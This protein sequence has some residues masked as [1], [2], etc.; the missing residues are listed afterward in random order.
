MKNLKRMLCGVLGMVLCLPAA[1]S[2]SAETADIS[3]A[4]EDSGVFIDISGDA[5]YGVF[6]YRENETGIT[7][8]SC[9]TSATAADIPSEID[10]KPVTEIGD[11]AFMNCEFLTNLVIPA[12]VQK[13][14]ESAFSN[15]PM[16][17]TVTLPEGL[18]ELGEGAFES[19]SMLSQVALPS[20][21]TELP[22]AAFYNCSYLPSFDVPATIQ[23]IGNEAFYSC[24]ALKEVTLPEGIETIGDYAFQNCQV[25]EQV[26]LPASC[27]ELGSYVF[28]GCQGLTALDVADGNA[29]YASQD[30]V[31]FTADGKTLI[32]Y[33]QAKDTASYQV[34][35]DCTALA[36]WSF[37]GSTVLEQIDLGNVT[38]IGEDCFYYCTSLKS[39][40]IPEGVTELKGAA[41]AY[42]LSMEE[43]QLPSTMKKLGNHCFYSCAK[44]KKLELPD[45]LTTLGDQCLYNCVALLQLNV[46]GSITEIGE[47]AIGY[48]TPSD[49]SGDEAKE[50]GRLH[51][52]N[53]GSKAVS[54]YMQQWKLHAYAPCLI[55]GAVI[56][57]VTGS[58]LL[59]VVLHRRRNQIRPTSRHA[60]AAKPKKRR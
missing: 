41:F 25:L 19:C 46:P 2:V 59:L 26:T 40:T 37:I 27:T 30:G 9:Q 42:C 58:I 5:T 22:E 28:D 50:I 10:G 3:T 20:T 44:L 33:P 29:A 6:T 13:V 57:V 35:E 56:I 45:G 36:D 47:Q 17:C 8:T 12:P 23:T 31:L 16:L 43:A 14:G 38:E 55:T 1:L 4:D 53:D 54:Q 21:L 48:Y 15:C 32:R 60:S 7:I 52:Y 49:A 18:T 24:T 51:V 39:V 34:P 11:A